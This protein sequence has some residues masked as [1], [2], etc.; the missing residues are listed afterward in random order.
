MSG[1][2]SAIAS[3]AAGACAGRRAKIVCTLGPATASDAMVRDLLRGGMD[4]ARLNFSHGTHE[5][6]A[7][8]LERVR[9]LAAEEGRTISVLQDLQGPKIRTGLLENHA[10][11]PLRQGASLTITTRNIPGTSSVISTGFAA[12]AQ[13]V[14]AGDRILLADGAIELRVRAVSGGDVECEIVNGGLLGEHQGISIPGRALSIPSLTEKDRQDLEFGLQ[15]GV[16]MVGLSFVRGANDVRA[17]K[18]LM[19][20]LI[21]NRDGMPPVIAKLEKPQAIQHLE[22]ILEAADA[23][24]VARGDLGVEMAPET[25]PFL[26][27]QIIRR[28]A[29]WRKPV[30]TATQMLESMIEHPRP[31][32]AEV[33]DVANAVG[34][35]SDAVML[36]AETSIGKYP[37]E[38][39]DF[40]AR[41]IVAAESHMTPPPAPCGKPRSLS[42]SE[43]ICESIAHAARDLEMRAIAVFTETGNTARLISKYR[44]PGP[45]LCFHAQRRGGQLAERMLGRTASLRRVR[46]L[47][48]GDAGDRRAG[49]AQAGGSGQGRRPGHRGGDAAGLRVHESV[50][51]ASG[52]M[53][54]ETFSMTE[55]FLSLSV[56]EPFDGME[57]EFLGVLHELYSL[58]EHKGY[59]RDVLLRNRLDPPSY[60]NV[61]HWTS[62]ATRQEAQEDPD[63]HR[64]WAQLGLLCHMRRIHDIL[65]EVDWRAER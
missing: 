48:G 24:M 56:M 63:L 11:V 60:I 36:S 26:Q 39:V 30:I 28:A 64:C 15:H 35:G 37:R 65:D 61:R 21:G 5:D 10:P 27:K 33:S 4:V 29:A 6:H 52:R 19:K 62:A 23:V 51:S 57:K 14:R 22:E 44:P 13:Q 18:S 42:I 45:R 32:R 38:A 7:R 43:T 25:V 46:N 41:I 55:T 9:R 54:T 53:T 49:I 58:L 3:A 34:E 12:L 16:D 17:L 40:M 47:G 50:T 31:T 20:S 59:S 8:T 2:I 1:E